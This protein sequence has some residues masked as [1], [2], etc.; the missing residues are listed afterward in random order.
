MQVC[1]NSR[2]FKSWFF[3]ILLIV[4]VIL[5]TL[6]TQALGKESVIRW[7]SSD[8]KSMDPAFIT[9]QNESSICMNIYSG[10]VKWKYGTTEIVP[11]LAESWDISKDGLV[12]TFHLRK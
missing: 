6:T 8:W 7:S 12:Y 10:L 2:L 4:S 3:L 11:D 9:L 5:T 1:R